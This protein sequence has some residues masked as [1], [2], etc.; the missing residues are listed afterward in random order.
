MKAGCVL[1]DLRL[2]S[3]IEGKSR[4]LFQTNPFYGGYKMIDP[5]RKPRSASLS[6][7]ERGEVCSV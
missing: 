1:Y 5:G 3:V 7:R 6:I 4:A 2:P